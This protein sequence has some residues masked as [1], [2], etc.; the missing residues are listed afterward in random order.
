[1]SE[2]LDLVRSLY[3]D[4]GRGDF[5]SAEWA[6]PEIDFAIIG[7]PTPYRAHGIAGMAQGTR[8]FLTAW[9]GYRSEAEEYRE[10]DDGRILVLTRDTA[11]GRTSGAVTQQMRAHVLHLH[12]GKV[13]RSVV[14]WDRDR[15]LADLGLTAEDAAGD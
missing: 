15:A 2:N 11:R 1:M 13:V 12:G 6:H 9:E 4:W 10:L 14:Y 7:G 8:E 5:S 3:V